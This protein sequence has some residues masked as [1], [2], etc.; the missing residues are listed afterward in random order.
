M[1]Y[2]DAWS[3][4]D[5]LPPRPHET[6]YQEGTMNIFVGNLNWS[7]TEAELEQLFYG[8]GTV[9]SVRIMTDRETGRSRG[10]AFVEMPD[11]T[12]AQAAIEG[13]NGTELGGRTLTVNEARQREDRGGPRREPRQPRW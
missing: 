10:F 2:L 3:G 12:A 13:L 6:T 5:M 1:D 11:T 7:T 4:A 8:Y 9:D